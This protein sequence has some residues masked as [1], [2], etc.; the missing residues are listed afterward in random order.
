MFE[1][2]TRIVYCILEYNPLLDSSNMTPKDWVKIGKDIE[3]LQPKHSPQLVSPS[4]L[5]PLQEPT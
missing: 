5:Q 4:H 2:N 1:N 3:V